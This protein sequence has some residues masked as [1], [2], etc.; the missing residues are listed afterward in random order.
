M[1]VVGSNNLGGSRCGNG[2]GGSRDG[3]GNSRINPTTMIHI[4]HLSVIT[5]NFY[6]YAKVSIRSIGSVMVKI[7]GRI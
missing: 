7:M 5:I 2:G 1:G 6:C 4:Y 3:G